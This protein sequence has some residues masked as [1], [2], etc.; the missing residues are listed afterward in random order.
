MKTEEQDPYDMGDFSRR[1]PFL[2]RNYKGLCF[3]AFAKVEAVAAAGRCTILQ[4]TMIQAGAQDDFTCLMIA[5]KRA[6]ERMG[7]RGARA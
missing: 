1:I 7:P 6:K 4:A 2:V 5:V 3:A